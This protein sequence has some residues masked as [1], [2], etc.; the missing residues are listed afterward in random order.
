MESEHVLHRRLSYRMNRLWQP[1]ELA[2]L[3]AW[4]LLS[5]LLAGSATHRSH[6]TEDLSRLV[7]AGVEDGLCSRQGLDTSYQLTGLFK[8]NGGSECSSFLSPAGSPEG[9]LD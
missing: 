4:P 6:G 5:V 1:T 2:V 8:I 7:D 3:G 9:L